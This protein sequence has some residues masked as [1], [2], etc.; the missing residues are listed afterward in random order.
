MEHTHGAYFMLMLWYPMGVCG[1][2]IRITVLVVLSNTIIFPSLLDTRVRLA[3]PSPLLAPQVRWQQVAQCRDEG[4][5]VVDPEE[6]VVKPRIG[7]V[8]QWI[9][10]VDWCECDASK[11]ARSADGKT[12]KHTCNRLANAATIMRSPYTVPNCLN[13]NMRPVS[14]G[15]D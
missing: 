10:C 15:E 2:V 7:Q 1:P 3:Q 9:L 14:S 8:I 6:R 12:C 5:E 4:Q 13:P 11:T